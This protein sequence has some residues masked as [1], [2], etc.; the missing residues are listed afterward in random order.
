MRCSLA[1]LLLVWCPSTALV[2]ARSYHQLH[3]TYAITYDND[4]EVRT[5]VA[6]PS[7]VKA[8]GGP[9]TAKQLHALRD[10]GE[11]GYRATLSDLSLAQY[12]TIYL[13]K[14]TIDANGKVTRHAYPP[15]HGMVHHNRLSTKALVIYQPYFGAGYPPAPYLIGKGNLGTGIPLPN[16]RLK[17]VLVHS[18]YTPAFRR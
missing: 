12:V 9:L 6:P 3:V 5:D 15:I 8:N 18:Y 17:R 2:Q 11:P 10:R 1:A 13:E 16:V 7:E 4:L 14:V